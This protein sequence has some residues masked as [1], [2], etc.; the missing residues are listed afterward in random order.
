MSSFTRARRERTELRNAAGRRLYLVVDGFAF[1]IGFEGSGLAVH[2]PAGF[3][4][5]G[6]SFPHWLAWA[7]PAKRTM[8][9]AAAVHDLLREDR[10]FSKLEG[11]AVFLTAMAAEGTPPLLRE[12]AFLL[13]RLNRTRDPPQA[14]VVDAAG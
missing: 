10:R 5:D 1:H 13:V 11:D 3:L 9:K 8:T 4:T 2:V 14:G 12:L 6:P 7:V